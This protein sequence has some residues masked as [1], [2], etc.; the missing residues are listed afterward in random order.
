MF[1]SF[2]KTLGFYMESSKNIFSL[3]VGVISYI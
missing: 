3:D 1:L 2:G